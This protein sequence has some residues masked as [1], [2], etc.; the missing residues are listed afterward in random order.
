MGI[1]QFMP[2]NILLFGQ[3]GDQDG[4][5]DLFVH[6]DAIMSIAK[7]LKNYGWYPGIDREKAGKVVF[8]YNH[9]QYYVDAVLKIRDLL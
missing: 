1:S 5:V 6:A 9:S 3:D 2:S 4:T 8:H 7:Y